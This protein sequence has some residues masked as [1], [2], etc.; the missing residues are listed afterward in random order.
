M[1]LTDTIKIH[2]STAAKREWEEHPAKIYGLL[3]VHKDLVQ[4][5][6]QLWSISHVGSGFRV[7]GELALKAA[8][9]IAKE[10][11]GMPEWQDP[12]IAT[13]NPNREVLSKLA[14]AVCE[15]RNFHAGLGVRL[16]AEAA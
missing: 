16:I 11:E 12:T 13:D 9:A 15:A 3:A 4:G 6:R 8:V 7:V 1:K 14:N 5:K 10:L 2:V